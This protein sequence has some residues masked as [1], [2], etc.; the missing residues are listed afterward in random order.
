MNQETPAGAKSGRTGQRRR[1]SD[2]RNPRP[3]SEQSTIGEPRDKPLIQGAGPR[4]TRNTQAGER[5]LELDVEG[6]D[7]VALLGPADA[8]LHTLAAF[9]RTRIVVRAGKVLLSGPAEEQEEL[10]ELFGRLVQRCRSGEAVTPELLEAEVG[11]IRASR[12]R[13][14]PAEAGADILVVRTPRKTIVAKSANQRAYLEAIARS[15]VVLAIGPAGTGKTY[16][17]VATAVEALVSGRANRIVLT[18]PAVEAG[19][20]LGFLPG[21]L[22]EKVDPYLRPLYDALFDM[23]PGER[24]RRLLEEEVIEVAP[25]AYMRGRTL[26]DSYIILDEAQNTTSTQMRMFLTRLGWNSKAIVTGDTTQIDLPHSHT[27]GLVE[28]ESLLGAVP[29]I[30]IVRFNETDVVRPPLVS[31]IITAYEARFAKEGNR[32]EDT[33]PEY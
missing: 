28:A 17:A 27:S 5:T 22:K 10:V 20:S 2:A 29:G 15:E 25:L 33:G 12:R 24:M 26:S 14:K 9:F 19:E 18:R 8:T 7:P 13:V 1:E 16:L 6:V 23:V 21:T 11:A 30:K 31:R 32:G 3:D 4:S